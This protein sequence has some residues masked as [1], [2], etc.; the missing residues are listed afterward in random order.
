M[1]ETNLRQAKAK[2]YITGLLAEKNLNFYKTNAKGERVTEN[3]SEADAEG[4]TGYVGIKTDETNIVRVNINVGK[5]VKSTG[6]PSK[7]YPGMLTIMNEYK[8]VAD[9]GEDEADKVHVS[10]DINLYQSGQTGAAVVAFKTSYMNRVKPTTDRPYEPSAT[11]EVEMVISKMLP[12]ITTEGEETGR[13]KVT[14]WVPVYNGVE[15]ITLIAPEEIAEPIQEYEPGQTV[16]F[17]G[18]I[19]SSRVRIAKEVPMKIGKPKIVYD[20]EN[21]DELII[22]GASEAYEEEVTPEKPYDLGAIKAAVQERKNRF[23]AKKASRENKVTTPAATARPSA[24]SRNRT[25]GF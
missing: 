9:A 21:K 11:Y 15:E 17:D 5:L 16:E 3:V 14:G 20:Y 6:E 4:I 24:A 2:A 18:D 23:E 12:E 10:G 8:S 22:T 13:V 1:A 19:I 25:L 7:T